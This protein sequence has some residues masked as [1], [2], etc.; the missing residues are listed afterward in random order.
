MILVLQLVWNIN[1]MIRWPKSEDQNQLIKIRWPKSKFEYSDDE[2]EIS[3]ILKKY[4]C[5]SKFQNNSEYGDANVP[6][7]T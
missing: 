3:K 2:N 4:Q 5:D 6:C 7:H 1:K